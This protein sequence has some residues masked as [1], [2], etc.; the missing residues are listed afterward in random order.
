[1]PSAA[2][3]QKCTSLGAYWKEFERRRFEVLKQDWD[4]ER[5]LFGD[6]QH[7]LHPCSHLYSQKPAENQKL[8][9]PRSAEGF[10]GCKCQPR[11]WKR[12]CRKS[13][14]GSRWEQ[15]RPEE[16]G[17]ER[18]ASGKRSRHRV[19][20]PERHTPGCWTARL[21]TEHKEG[22]VT[23]SMTSGRQQPTDPQKAASLL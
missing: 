22:G 4:Q 5:C 20:Q 8:E 3:D 2:A 10:C 18:R 1:M 15:E 23:H 17:E 11:F 12:G 7:Q 16:P 6:I 13:S 19:L 21:K 14:P 9:E